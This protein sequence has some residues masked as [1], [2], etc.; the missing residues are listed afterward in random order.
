MT[1]FYSAG[2]DT[3]IYRDC[4]GAGGDRRE[5]KSKRHISW[6]LLHHFSLEKT[7]RKGTSITEVGSSRF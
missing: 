2:K 5:E 3:V 7:N 1:V 4:V 6:Q